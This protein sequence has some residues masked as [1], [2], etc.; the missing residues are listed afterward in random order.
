VN[1]L[2]KQENQSTIVA[3]R[4]RISKDEPLALKIARVDQPANANFS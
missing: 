4:H 2:K 1:V 3:T